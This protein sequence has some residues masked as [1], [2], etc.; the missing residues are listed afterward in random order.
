[1]SNSINVSVSTQVSQPY[2]NTETHAALNKRIWKLSLIFGDL[3]ID[4]NLAKVAH[5][6]KTKLNITFF[7][8]N[9]GS[10]VFKVFEY[11]DWLAN[12]GK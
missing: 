12:Y 9:V 3:N 6:S 1:M 8:S 2:S 4:L 5:A 7:R 10:E 11:V